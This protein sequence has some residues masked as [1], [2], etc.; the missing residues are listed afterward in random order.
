M[1]L[2]FKTAQGR[3]EV[4]ADDGQPVGRAFNAIRDAVT[5]GWADRMHFIEYDDLTGKPGKTMEKIYDFL[6][7]PACEHNFGNVEQVT[8][9]DDAVYGF[10]DLHAIRPEVKPQQPQWPTV[11]DATVTNSP[12]WKNIE[13]AAHFW[14][15]YPKKDKSE[16]SGISY[17]TSKTIVN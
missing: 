4:F 2:K 5:R 12:V 3:V 17:S 1:A 9:E 14:R 15:A 16:F 11:F 8:L 10:K 6:G 13:A 7:E